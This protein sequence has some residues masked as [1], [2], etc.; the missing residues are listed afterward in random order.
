MPF[1]HKFEIRFMLN[2]HILIAEWKRMAFSVQ[3]L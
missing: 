1:G 3:V 2:N